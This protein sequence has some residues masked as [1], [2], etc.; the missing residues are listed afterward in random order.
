MEGLVREAK[1]RPFSGT[2]YTLGR[3]TMALSPSLTNQ[4]FRDLGLKPFGGPAREDQVDTVT[5]YSGELS[6]GPIR[7]VEFFRMLGFDRTMAID[8][9]DFEG[10]DII[11]DLNRELPAELAG[12]CDLLVDG[13]T[14]DN[15]FDPIT[16]LRSAT[17]LLKLNGRICL[18]IQGNY[19]TRY[20]GIPYLIFT[21]IW[22][23]DYFVANRF[24]DCQIY[25]SIWTTSGQS[26][27]VINH[28]HATRKW[29]NGIIKPVLSEFPM[30]ICV[31][32]ER[33]ENSSCDR[34]PNQHVYRT[35]SE[36]ESYEEVVRSIIARDRRPHIRSWPPENSYDVPPGWHQVLADWSVLNPE[37][38]QFVRQ[39]D[40]SSF[41]RAASTS[42]YPSY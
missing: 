35:A 11:V 19:S 1:Y 24:V 9:S 29:G 25:V 31:F 42:Y 2:A 20:N 18:S 33:D 34:I 15:L 21:P 32:A 22:L 41:A 5:A 28:E 23:Y 39:A 27:Y 26:A 38:Q 4:R 3:P 8:V 37:T 40:T 16:A 6:F 10:A 14:L 7:D 17:R 30:Q 13:S 12:T 36:W